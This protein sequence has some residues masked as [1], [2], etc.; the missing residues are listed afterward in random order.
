MGAVAVVL[1]RN[2]PTL[3]AGRSPYH[4]QLQHYGRW[5]PLALRR[6]EEQTQT[7]NTN[8]STGTHTDTK[9]QQQQ[10]QGQKQGLGG[11][12]T[13]GTPGVHLPLQCS[14]VRYM[15][16]L[17]GYALRAVCVRRR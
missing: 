8:K 2:L 13:G 4:G 14:Q 15:M 10:P 7:L 11:E 6:S 3:R 9:P 5:E 17:R 1:A 16:P 12:C